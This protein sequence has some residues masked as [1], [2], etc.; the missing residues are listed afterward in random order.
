MKIIDLSM[1]IYS[2]M[3]VFQGDPEDEITQEATIEND[4]WNMKRIHMNS[5]DATHLNVPIH[6]KE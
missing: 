2:G 5:H 6:C 3:P 4:E 1:E